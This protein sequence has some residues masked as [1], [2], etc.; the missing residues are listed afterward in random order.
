MWKF[1]LGGVLFFCFD[2]CLVLNKFV[3]LVLVVSLLVLLIYWVV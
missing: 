2:G 3:G 1:V